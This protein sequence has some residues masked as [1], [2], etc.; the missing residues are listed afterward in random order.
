MVQKHELVVNKEGIGAA[1]TNV[2]VFAET[3]KFMREVKYVCK[4]CYEAF[5]KESDHKLFPYLMDLI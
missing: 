4:E 3:M 1:D 5:I 2:R